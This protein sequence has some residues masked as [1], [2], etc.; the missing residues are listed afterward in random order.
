MV[1]PISCEQVWRQLSS[2]LD[3]DLDA[4]VCPVMEDHIKTCPRCASVAA[5][6]RN[7]IRLYG[8]ERMVETTVTRTPMI[9]RRT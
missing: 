8:D 5:G 3:G 7:V 1:N 9:F 6:M 2:Y 4:S